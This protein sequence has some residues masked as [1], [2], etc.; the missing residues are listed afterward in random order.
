MAGIGGPFDRDEAAE[1]VNSSGQGSWT[2]AKPPAESGSS[3]NSGNT[4]KK[5][6]RTQNNADL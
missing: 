3:M 6:A 4:V 2:A 5:L 1:L